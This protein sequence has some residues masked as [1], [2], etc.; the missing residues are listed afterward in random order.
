MKPK[1]PHPLTPI[2]P[3]N[4]NVKLIG[5][6]GVGSIVARNWALF[7]AAQPQ[8]SRFTFIDGDQFEP[9]N[10]SRMFFGDFGNKAEVICL[11]LKQQLHEG[12]VTLEFIPEYITAEN[13]PKLIQNGD[14]VFMAVDNH[15]TRK[16]VSDYCETLNNITL[17]SGGN[18]GITETDRGTYGNVQVYIRKD[19]K[20][21]TVPITKFHPEIR[22]PQGKHPKD[23]SCTE[24]LESTPQ[25]L[26]ANLATASHMLNAAYLYLCGAAHYQEMGFDIADGRAAVIMESGIG[27]KG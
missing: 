15:A 24:A 5:L 27:V 22:N 3:F 13:A 26:F 18:D 17:I 4:S 20:D 2:L 1:L 12:S 11:D 8:A 6:G 23:I 7:A 25:I 9:G 19:G 21:V 16:L 10:F 14:I